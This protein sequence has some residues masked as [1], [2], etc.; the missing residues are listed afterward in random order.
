MICRDYESNNGVYQYKFNRTSNTIVIGHS[1]DKRK[2][3]I[4]NLVNQD[5][6]NTDNSVIVF[7]NNKDNIE[8]F[9]KFNKRKE[10][11]EFSIDELE[12][13][14][15]IDIYKGTENQ[16]YNR[17]LNTFRKLGQ[18]Y[19][20]YTFTDENIE[21]LE[22]SILVTKKV[23]GYKANFED[24]INIILNEDEKGLK[25]IN[26][27][28]EIINK[29]KVK[30]N[31]NALVYSW[32][33]NKYYKENNK[34]YEY[35]NKLRELLTKLKP[36][37][38]LFC[39]GT[40]E[41]KEINFETLLENPHNVIINLSSE[42]KN[43]ISSFV[44]IVGLQLLQQAT[45][46]YKL[47]NKELM[48]CIYI[49]NID[50]LI[51]NGFTNMLCNPYEKNISINLFIDNKELISKKF[52][53][54]YLDKLLKLINSYIIFT[55]EFEKN[56]EYYKDIIRAHLVDSTLNEEEIT[57]LICKLEEYTAPEK[58]SNKVLV[59][60]YVDMKGLG[61]YLGNGFI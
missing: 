15:Y 24:F 56:E 25:I 41:D 55:D 12:S 31:H 27:F 52:G 6:L 33:K 37:L 44:G 49:D 4:R 46:K 1:N 19:E 35:N 2:E 47:T 48:N 42:S 29:E 21:L 60:Y 23:Y 5:L 11:I 61:N 39:C 28:Y 14:Y 38:K 32:F 54:A 7:E 26:E 10:Y 17:L 22:K 34:V 16:V 50:A 40:E 57:K 13:N 36:Y 30:S 58:D 3:I 9:R 45:L 59:K 51:T 18:E 8:Y 53:K 20:Q 43:E